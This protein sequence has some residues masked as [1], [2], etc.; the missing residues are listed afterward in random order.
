MIR[1]QYWRCWF[2]TLIN[3]ICWNL[4]LEL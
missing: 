4:Y 3:L 1:I 2:S